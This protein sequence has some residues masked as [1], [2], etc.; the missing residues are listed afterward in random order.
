MPACTLLVV[1]GTATLGQRGDGEE[2]AGQRGL[3]GIAAGG[4]G[5][6]GARFAALPSLHYFSPSLLQL[7]PSSPASCSAPTAYCLPLLLC[8]ACSTGRMDELK[9]RYL[10]A[11]SPT[12]PDWDT[13]LKGL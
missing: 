13:L 8:L 3:G 11:G 2:E 9:Q 7:T 6:W 10:A 4:I 5:C 1:P 12:N